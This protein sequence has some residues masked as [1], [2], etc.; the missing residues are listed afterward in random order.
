LTVQVAEVEAS[1]ARIGAG[2]PKGLQ[3][4]FER[5]IDQLSDLIRLTQV[6]Q[7]GGGSYY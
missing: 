5:Q 3:E 7:A 2:N 4:Q 6:R 1:F